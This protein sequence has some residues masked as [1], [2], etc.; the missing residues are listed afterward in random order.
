MDGSG[1]GQK[2]TVCMW[3]DGN[4]TKFIFFQA[5]T[6]T[7]PA[8]W[9]VFSA[10]W[11]FHGHSNACMSFFFVWELGKKRKLFTGLRSVRI[12]KN[13]DVCHSF[14]LYGPPSRQITYMS[15]YIL[16]RCSLVGVLK[17][18]FVNCGCPGAL[19]SVC[20]LDWLWEFSVIGYLI[21]WHILK[22]H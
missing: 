12:V 15:A 1:I 6:V 20:F 10:V 16:E 7:N 11:I 19:L 18:V 3:L 9:L 8:I 4:I 13:C 5:G 14:S 2:Y 22:S 21:Y 17:L